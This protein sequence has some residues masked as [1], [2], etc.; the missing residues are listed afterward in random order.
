MSVNALQQ[1]LGVITEAER[2]AIMQ[3]YNRKTALQELALTM[4]ERGMTQDTATY[5][6]VLNDLG[7]AAGDMS[8]WWRTVSEHYAW[9]YPAGA[10]WRVDFDS[11]TVSVY[12]PN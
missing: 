6:R 3:I 2:D 8:N 10:N 9:Q 7:V 4:V 12:M 1:V 5:Q 11:R